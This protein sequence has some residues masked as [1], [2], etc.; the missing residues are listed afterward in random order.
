MKKIAK[1]IT[2][3][4]LSILSLA[5]CKKDFLEVTPKGKLI[6]Q[7]TGDYDLILNQSSLH[8]FMTFSPMV[9]G[10]EVTGSPNFLTL[11]FGASTLADQE[12]FKWAD[13]IFLPSNTDSEIT[14]MVKQIYIY[15]KVIKEV[16]SSTGGTEAQKRSILA[17]ALTGRAW[18]NFMLV[19][20]YGK[21]YNAA[22]AGTDLASPLFMNADV[23]Q[24][25]FTRATVQQLYNQVI[26]DLT[27]AI[28]L[29]PENITNRAR[30]SK[31]TAQA[32]LG[33][34]YMFMQKWEEAAPLLNA[35]IAALPAATIDVGLYDYHKEFAAGGT[36]LPID[37]MYGPSRLMVDL[38]KEVAYMK[39]ATR[40]YA[41]GLDGVILS[42]SAAALFTP[43]DERL[44]FYSPQTWLTS[45]TY[46]NGMLR[47]WGQSY[48]NLGV[49]VPDVYLLAAECKA[50][51]GKINEAAEDI[52]NFRLT[53][54]PQDE[55]PVPSAIAGSK[56]SLVKY[57]LEERIRE[58]AITGNRW[59]DMRRLS[60]DPEYAGTIGA[61]HTIVDIKGNITGTYKLRPERLTMRFP[62][63]VMDNNP[64]MTNNP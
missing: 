9:M 41:A 56:V 63:Y 57:I 54:V 58:Q 45:E 32:I 6:A 5:G 46:P 53:R 59:F 16:M 7:K 62:I 13:D 3:F 8:Q 26:A 18:V 1:N 64:G 17:E 34:V 38:D 37:P 19:N 27:Q 61:T 42:A 39:S 12:A 35:F 60:V 36:F 21:P 4:S 31:P 24:T 11:G 55:A 23:T 43:G 48:A 50:R 29:L 2:V 28:P 25:T 20:L 14:I 30:A 15:N 52:R 33:K 22:T 49:T 10:D 47:A 40:M 51:L 44:K